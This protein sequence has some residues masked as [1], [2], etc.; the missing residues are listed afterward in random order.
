[1]DIKDIFNKA[2]ERLEEQIEEAKVKGE[3]AE[4]LKLQEKIMRLYMQT[5]KYRE[6]AYFILSKAIQEDALVQGQK[7][8]FECGTENKRMANMEC[9]VCGSEVFNILDKDY[10]E[11]YKQ[12]CYCMECVLC[13]KRKWYKLDKVEFEEVKQEEEENREVSYEIEYEEEETCEQS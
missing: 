10:V 7:I 11:I 5:R 1:M 13:G 3:N 4:G 12:T 9:E 8:S 2:K 6:D